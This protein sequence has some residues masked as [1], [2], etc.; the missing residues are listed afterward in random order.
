MNRRDLLKAIA[1][2]PLGYALLKVGGLT[3]SAWEDDVPE[4]WDPPKSLGK[5]HLKITQGSRT[6]SYKLREIEAI[7]E[8]TE[9]SVDHIDDWPTFAPTS[10]ALVAR[11]EGFHE[12]RIDLG[13]AAIEFEAHGF[14]YSFDGRIRG[15]I[16]SAPP[17]PED[18]AHTD[19]EIDCIGWVHTEVVA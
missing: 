11:I 12:G 17:S 10:S 18:V 1:A 13:R 3:E 7:Q 15:I 14:R 4:G 19:V 16:A 2:T 9:I 8:Q 6:E 5:P